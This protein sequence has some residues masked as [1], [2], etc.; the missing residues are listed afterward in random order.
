MSDYYDLLDRYRRLTAVS[1]PLEPVTTDNTKTTTR[2]VDM[3]ACQW[4][5]DNEN[6]TK[7]SS[8]TPMGNVQKPVIWIGGI[9]PINQ[10][11]RYSSPDLGK[12][13]L[14]KIL[15]EPV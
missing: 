8:F 10:T 2:N 3:V 12:G 5:R 11:S 4:L 15:V 14:L 6:S 9:F 13:D 1:G 7:L